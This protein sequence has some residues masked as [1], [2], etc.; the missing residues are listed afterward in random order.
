[1]QSILKLRQ[2]LEKQQ[3]LR[4]QEIHQH[5]HS[6]R[7]KY[8]GLEKHLLGEQERSVE[9]MA[10]GVSA[11]ELQ[12]AQQ[13]RTVIEIQLEQLRLAIVRLDEFRQKQTLVYQKAR[14][15]R[16]VLEQLR[17]QQ[18]GAY[19]AKQARDSQ[20]QLDDLFLQRRKNPRHG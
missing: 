9:Q 1:M 20:R 14:S 11:A 18:S 16:E 5:L 8:A 13:C 10:S 3:E 17:N 19:S 4:L 12:F 15:D 2:G 7:D 6:L